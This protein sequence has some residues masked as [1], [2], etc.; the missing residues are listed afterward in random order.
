MEKSRLYSA[1]LILSGVVG[2]VAQAA[3]PTP[4]P[5]NQFIGAAHTI[6]G[7]VDS[8][9]ARQTA[10][11]STSV[12]PSPTSS[13]P[14][15]VTSP[16]AAAAAAAAPSKP[17]SDHKTLI[18]AVVCAVVGAFLVALLVGLCCWCLI[19]RRRRRREHAQASIDDEVK[20]WRSNKPANPGRQYSNPQKNSPVSAIEQQPMIPIG[21]KEPDMRHHPALRNENPFVPIPPSPRKAPNSRPGLTDDTVPGAPSY[22]V[23]ETQRLRKSSS[24]SRSRSHPR[25]SSNN[26]LPT[27]N[28]ASQPSTPFGLSGI[29]QPYGDM[30]V[31]VL[32]TEA[33]SRELQQSL[34]NREPVYYPTSEPVQRHHTPPTVPSRSP[35]RLSQGQSQSQSPGLNHGYSTSTAATTPDASSTE[36]SSADDWRYNKQA[37][38]SS[39]APWEA[40]QHRYTDNAAMIQAPPI[41]WSERERS[42]H[43]LSH[44]PRHSSNWPRHSDGSG[45]TPYVDRSRR[46]SRSPATSVNGQPKRLRFSD[47]Q[48]DEY[49]QQRYSQGVGEAL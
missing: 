30:H 8:A 49:D 15:A 25:T 17:G 43:S 44:S 31:H 21:A 18:I 6:A 45:G 40:R 10:A 42:R 24:R 26:H 2:A 14:A 22:I 3:S 34:N 47:L 46:N 11:P 39:V 23:P 37:Q 36:D 16:T 5:L 28:T 4:N 19:R 35:N 41:P 32:R 29:G 1:I 13:T 48:G 12:L 9:N 7:A 33:P 38:F 20:T 27:T